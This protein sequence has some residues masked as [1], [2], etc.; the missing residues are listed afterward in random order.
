[1]QQ[2]GTANEGRG[3]CAT[4]NVKEQQVAV[5]SLAVHALAGTALETSWNE[6]RHLLLLIP[7]RFAKGKERSP[8]DAEHR[9]EP[10]GVNHLAERPGNA[11]P[12]GTVNGRACEVFG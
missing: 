6:E 5:R 3:V 11:R 4:V 8:R 1:M 12:D 10:Q 9:A 2:F 7:L